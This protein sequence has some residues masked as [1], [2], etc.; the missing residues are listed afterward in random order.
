MA[1]TKNTFIK[2]RMNKDLDE[3]LIPNGEYRDALN[4]E[5]SQS[6]GSDVGTVNTS[7]GN[8]KLTDFDLTNNCEAKIIGVFAD[9]KNKD[10]YVFITN[11]I[12]TSTDKLSLFASRNALCQIWKRNI[13]TNSNIK[14][15]EGSFLNFSLT[16]FF[17]AMI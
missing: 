13:E 12:D 8:I 10:I 7:L 14:L 5:I 9:E 2:S 11:F 6:E 3:R 1:Q 4:V 15:V 17:F 16:N